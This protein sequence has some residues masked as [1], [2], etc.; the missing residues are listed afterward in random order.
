[1]MK[2]ADRH[3]VLWGPPGSGKSTVGKLVALRLGRAFVELDALVERDA[4]RSIPEIFS[5][6]GERAFRA[7]ERAAL[8]GVLERSD[9]TV[10]AVGGGALVDPVLR[11]EVLART[12]VVRLHAP[13]TTLAARVGKEGGRRPLVGSDPQADLTRLLRDRAD[14]YAAG[15]LPVDAGRSPEAVTETIVERLTSGFASLSVGAHAYAAWMAPGSGATCLAGLLAG[16]APSSVHVVIDARVHE[17][18]ADGLLD[19]LSVR[20]R[21]IHVVGPGESAKGFGELERLLRELIEAGID[22]SSVVVAVGGGATSDLAG[23]AAALCA[24]GVAWIAVPTTLLAMVDAAI[25]GKTAVNLG[26]IKNPVG[27]FHHPAAV[28][29]DPHLSRTE[30]QRAFVSGLAEVVKTALLGDATL[31]EDIVADP[32]AYTFRDGPA[33]ED[34]ILRC[35]RVKARIVQADPDERTGE[36][37]LLNLG[38]TAGHALEAEADGGLLHG[39]A[40]AMGLEAALSLG[41]AL[42]VTPAGLRERAVRALR[43]LGL[44]PLR[45]L[46]PSAIERVGFDKK[47]RGSNVQL[48]IV[49]AAESVEVISLPVEELRSKLRKL[50]EPVA[51]P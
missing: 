37:I 45:G 18:A 10:I 21:S 48:V 13:L 34:A 11:E 16:L 19:D 2:P 30:P 46:P 8:L 7:R 15:H 35:A 44:P 26:G 3:I 38:H 51:L 31:F 32:A 22:R 12:L 20:P 29:L 4:G 33:V 23:L 42:H 6:E 5:F 50:G 24:R 40:V 47:R 27:V 39:E 43:G 17:I 41:E 14:A 49:R 9:P 36:R 1:M 28:I 25:G